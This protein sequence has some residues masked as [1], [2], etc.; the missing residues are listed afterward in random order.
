MD[1]PRPQSDYQ[2]YLVALAGRAT[3]PTP[4]LDR[5]MPP[6]AYFVMLLTAAA[7]WV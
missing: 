6:L 2:Y 5:K 3:G 7:A 4:Y 1:R